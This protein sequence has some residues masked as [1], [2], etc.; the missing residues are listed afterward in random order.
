MTIQGSSQEVLG[1]LRR[2]RIKK[3]VKSLR[4]RLFK[5]EYFNNIDDVCEAV[6]SLVKP[7]EIVGKGGSVAL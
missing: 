2:A 7:G 3:A 6:A 4:Q 1:W 5:A